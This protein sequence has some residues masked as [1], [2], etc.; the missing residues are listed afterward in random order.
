M[1]GIRV[2]TDS[3]ADLPERLQQEARLAMVPLSV[4][5]GSESLLDKVEI[6]HAEFIRRL[7]VTRTLPTTSQPA[8]GRFEEVY[9]Q[10]ADDGAEGI[11]S[12]H[13]SEKLSGTVGSARIAAEAVADRVPVT[14][15]DSRT[16]T[17]GLGFLALEAARV[18]ATGADLA[19]VAE[20]VR[21]MIPNIHIIFF[22]DT[23]EYLQKGGRI[24]RA[25]MIAG[26]ILSLKPLMRLDEGVVVPHER[27]RTRTKAIDGLVK[28][29]KDFPQIRQ[30]GALQIGDAEIE[31]L[32]DRLG[33]VYPREKIVVTDVSPVIAVH[34]GPG[35][36]G[37]V[38]DA[39]DPATLL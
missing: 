4:N 28:F 26:S 9:R 10:L 6:T 5:F 18:A 33:T 34:V 21:K 1:A 36:L 31:T 23:L 15:L 13:I 14:V 2:V 32:L 35:T 16:I 7:K 22:A 30:L 11:I 20:A 24:G 29:V 17:L 39:G 37:V 3:T 27:T 25:A 12:I 38:I 19:A 8:P